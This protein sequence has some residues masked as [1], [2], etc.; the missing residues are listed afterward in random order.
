[1]ACEVKNALNR[2]AVGNNFSKCYRR[3][4]INEWLIKVTTMAIEVPQM[5][6]KL[7]GKGTADKGV[8]TRILSPEEMPITDDGTRADILVS[9]DAPFG[10]M[11]LGALLEPAYNAIAEK[12]VAQMRDRYSIPNTTNA[13][14]LERHILR[15]I[16]PLATDFL[17]FH[18]RVGVESKNV[19]LGMSE[20]EILSYLISAFTTGVPEYFLPIDREG[21]EVDRNKRLFE[22]TVDEPILREISFYHK[23][24]LIKGKFKAVIGKRYFQ[25]LEQTA[26]DISAS[27]SSTMQVTGM[28]AHKSPY[29][30]FGRRTPT[31]TTRLGN[32]ETRLIT[33]NSLETYSDREMENRDP[34]GTMVAELI[35]RN[36]SRKDHELCIKAILNADEPGRITRLIDRKKHP[37]STVRVVG[38]FNSIALSQGYRYVQEG[39]EDEPVF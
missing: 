19:W 33:Y 12:F 31:I 13:A 39:A 32:S 3:T 20:S 21:N 29:T 28:V 25:L 8:I 5:A 2:L 36:G 9:L 34:E 24:E 15:V 30:D 4:P 37:Y 22:E 1:M 16:G 38:I 10:R 18:D 35:S 23:G 6:A 26:Q 7:T 14:E 27:A 17:Y 11:T